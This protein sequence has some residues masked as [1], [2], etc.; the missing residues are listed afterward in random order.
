MLNSLKQHWIEFYVT[1]QNLP[2]KY[3]KALD[4]QSEEKRKNR[5]YIS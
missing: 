2:I 3:P 5:L 4:C 1:V